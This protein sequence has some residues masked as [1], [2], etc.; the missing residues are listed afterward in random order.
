MDAFGNCTAL[1][2]CIISVSYLGGY[3]A[4]E[5]FVFIIFASYLHIHMVF[6]DECWF[7]IAG[8]SHHSLDSYFHFLELQSVACEQYLRALC[9]AHL[10]PES[11]FSIVP[12]IIQAV[13]NL[14]STIHSSP[15]GTF[16]DLN[17]DQKLQNIRFEFTER[18]SDLIANVP[19]EYF[20]DW[21]PQILSRL[22]SPGGV[23]L[24]AIIDRVAAE[25][26][27]SLS[28]PLFFAEPLLAE[29]LSTASESFEDRRD[30][31]VVRHSILKWCESEAV[32]NKHV[33]NFIDSMFLLHNP[34]LR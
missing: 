18:W 31:S 25:M 8:I 27:S 23:Y 10:P 15:D 17:S 12:C 33:K 1:E 13:F 14:F 6:F 24:C 22:S 30:A 20:I 2:F 4:I 34:D 28:Y 5:I 16:Q 29:K 21:I 7:I 32:R 3:F 9:S 19:V 26:P 11:S